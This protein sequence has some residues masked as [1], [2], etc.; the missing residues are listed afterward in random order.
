MS[1][2][3]TG[4]LRLRAGR[5]V[6]GPLSLEIP[7]GEVL[8]LLGPNGAGKSTLL[9]LLAGAL[10]PTAG[11]IQ[12]GGVDLALAPIEARRLLGYLPEHPPLYPD[13]TVD[14][15]LRF[16]AGLRGLGGARRRGA[17]DRAKQLCGLTE[18]GRRVLGHLS[19]GYQQRIGIAQAIVHGPAVVLLDEPT[20]ALDP[21]TAHAIREVIREIARGAGGSGATVVISSH[22]LDEV[23][24]LCQR[25]LILAD[26]T[27]LLDTRLDLAT[28]ESLDIAL[29]RPPALEVLA[30]LP[31]VSA[32]AVLPPAGHGVGAFRLGVDPALLPAERLA[33]L[34]VAADWGLT[35]LRPGRTRMEETLFA[36]V[37]GGAVAVDEQDGAGEGGEGGAQVRPPPPP[38]SGD[39]REAA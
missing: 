6:L 23:E 3:A 30:A 14:G 26:G 9:A 7:A 22:Y 11:E 37:C 34:A 4:L 31:G 19:K 33:A 28:T 39:E 18:V 29:A 36:V 35:G 24:S 38:G 1:I 21:P 10:A 5:R 12:I 2:A 8:G 16:V 27:P 13:M 20:V 25:A 32:V 17:V 15:Y